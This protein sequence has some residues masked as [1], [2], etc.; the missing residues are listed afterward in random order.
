MTVS[1]HLLVQTQRVEGLNKFILEQEVRAPNISLELLSS[2]LSLC[3]QIGNEVIS[4]CHWSRAPHKLLQLQ[5]WCLI[6]LEDCSRVLSNPLRRAAPE[7]YSIENPEK[8]KMALPI[9]HPVLTNMYSKSWAIAQYKNIKKKLKVIV[10]ADCIGYCDVALQ[11]GFGANEGFI[12][13][14]VTASYGVLCDITRYG[15][16]AN[17]QP[18]AMGSILYLIGRKQNETYTRKGVAAYMQRM[19]KPSPP[20]PLDTIQN[21]E[22]FRE[23]G[24]TIFGTMLM[25]MTWTARQELKQ[26][27]TT[28]QV[29]IKM[30][31]LNKSCKMRW[32]PN[33]LRISS[34]WVRALAVTILHS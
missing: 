2:K 34:R 4:K 6:H 14:L 30:K 20:G 18:Y 13:V 9:M 11:L 17:L 7:P 24:M 1:K 26:R 23:L 31:L 22:I 19:E 10:E 28:M 33:C 8:F 3:S 21:H 25:K 32:M 16:K 5:E 12:P 15:D 29:L 27:L